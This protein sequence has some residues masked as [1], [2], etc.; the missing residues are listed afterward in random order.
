MGGIGLGGDRRMDRGK[1][2]SDGLWA[3]LSLAVT[4][5]IGW[6]GASIAVQLAALALMASLVW[7]W[8]HRPRAKVVLP[9]T[10]LAVAALAGSL[11]EDRPIS[12]L[13]A[14]QL[15]HNQ[16]Y[17]DSPEGDK[18][19]GQVALSVRILNG[20]ANPVYAKLVGSSVSLAGVA[21]DKPMAGDPL[22]IRQ[23]NHNT[24]V[25]K[26]I[27]FTPPRS[28]DDEFDGQFRYEMAFDHKIDGSYAEKMTVKGRWTFSPTSDGRGALFG[29]APDSDSDKRWIQR[30][31]T[32][33]PDRSGS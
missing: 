10:L 17:T 26:P 5:V 21:D 1:V 14:Y 2:A 18:R 15:C 13:L 7:W 30:D 32:I 20:D 28:V 25:T 19:V 3:I 9:I 4:A 22:L 33:Q 29:I 23:E 11:Y 24:Y 12:Y 8:G 27:V 31:C 6:L 16:A